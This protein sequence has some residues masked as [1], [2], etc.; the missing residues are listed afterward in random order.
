MSTSDR[1]P[2][3]R[4]A[5]SGWETATATMFDWLDATS[6]TSAEVVVPMVMD[7]VAPTSVVD[8]GCGRGAWL[9]EFRRAGVEDVLGV[10]GNYVDRSSLLIPEASFRAADLRRPARLGRQFDLAVCLEVGEHLP[11]DA[12][13][14]LV[15]L[16]T[17]SAPAVLFS[18]AIPGQ[19]GSGHVNEQWPRYWRSRFEER[20][21]RAF[22]L[23]RSRLW[24]DSRV[25][26]WYRQ[27]T[28][29]YA[30]E[31][32]VAARPAIA[33]D[34]AGDRLPPRLVHPDLF[35]RMVRKAEPSHHSVIALLRALP[36]AAA[37]TVRRRLQ[38]RRRPAGD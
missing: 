19:G 13:R 3:H 35:E 9:A 2:A 25:A 23:L 15:G 32:F 26:V 22:D 36:A 24:E 8:V 7:L 31:R 11:D 21:F 6:R 33:A 37:G 4:R 5:V 10:D 17:E 18:A 14:E 27:N 1:D 34:P 29:L 28:F 30:N 12:S 20:G 16:L 38:A